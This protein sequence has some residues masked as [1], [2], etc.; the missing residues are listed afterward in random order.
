LEDIDMKKKDY[1]KPTMRVVK[2]HQRSNILTG[3]PLQKVSAK[4]G[5]DDL[6]LE[7]DS[8]SGDIWGN[9]Y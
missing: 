3:S 8:E 6:G 4:R 7:Y 9:A 2:L 1:L 5:D